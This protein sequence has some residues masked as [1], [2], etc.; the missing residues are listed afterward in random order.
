MHLSVLH[1]VFF[2]CLPVIW[3]T[4]NHCSS[5]IDCFKVFRTSTSSFVP[6]LFSFQWFFLKDTLHIML[7]FSAN[8]FNTFL[9]LWDFSLIQLNKWGKKIVFLRQAANKGSKANS[10]LSDTTWFI[11]V[12]CF[13][14]AWHMIHRSVVRDWICKTHSTE[15]SQV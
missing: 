5:G 4:L 13:F 2:G 11:W 8:G 10:L 1:Q 14:Y 15:N 6:H 12:R 9:C 3:R 7:K